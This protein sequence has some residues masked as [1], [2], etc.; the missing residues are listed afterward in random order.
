MSV[1][2]HT[3]HT[4]LGNFSPVSV[5]HYG[6]PLIFQGDSEYWYALDL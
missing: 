1:S 3:I 6:A 4:Y 2:I 5:W